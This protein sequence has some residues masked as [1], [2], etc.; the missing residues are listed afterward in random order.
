MQESC[1]VLRIPEGDTGL[2]QDE[3][4]PAAFRCY[5]TMGDAVLGS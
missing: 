4:I 5:V 2:V 3:L 1:V